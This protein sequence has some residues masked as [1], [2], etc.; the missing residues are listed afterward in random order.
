MLRTVN[1]RG[2]I[3]ICHLLIPGEHWLL[4]S[5]LRWT[6][7]AIS[8]RSTL[9]TMYTYYTSRELAIRLHIYLYHTTQ[10]WTAYNELICTAS[11]TEVKFL[12][13]DI[14]LMNY[15]CLCCH[16]QIYFCTINE[17]QSSNT[18][19]HMQYECQEYLPHFF[20]TIT[21]M[22]IKFVLSLNKKIH[23]RNQALT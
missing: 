2:M 4:F 3:L 9:P 23:V 7:F 13:V 14:A 20:L 17:S 18:N 1:L 22:D 19:V 8:F 6:M 5:Y 11:V 12:S 15:I 16:R 10:G 21:A